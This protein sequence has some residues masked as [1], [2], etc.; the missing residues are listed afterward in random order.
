[1][2]LDQND[3]N[4]ANEFTDKIDVNDEKKTNYDE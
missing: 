2:K 4:D 3:D 1:M